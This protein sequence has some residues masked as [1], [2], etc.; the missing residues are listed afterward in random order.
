MNNWKFAILDSQGILE[1]KKMRCSLLT[2]LQRDGIELLN[3]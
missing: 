2:M 3:F 1:V